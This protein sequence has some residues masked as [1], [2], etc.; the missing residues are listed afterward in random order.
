MI[1]I[2]KI[3]KDFLKSTRKRKRL[4]ENDLDSHVLL[5]D[6][7]RMDLGYKLSRV[8]GSSKVFAEY[9]CHESKSQRWDLCY[10]DEGRNCIEIKFMR[11]IPSGRNRPRTQ[12]YGSIL[13]D[14]FK[15]KL[16]SKEGSD[17]YFILITDEGFK[18]YL[19]RKDFPIQEKNISERS[20]DLENIPK[21]A[22]GEVYKRLNGDIPERIDF[23]M[24][25]LDKEKIEDLNFYL[26]KIM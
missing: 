25:L 19:V 5:E 21:T 13:S 9:P 3:W 4:I 26:M 10:F 8:A 6:T 17:L 11:P 14:L 20:Y 2:R 1:D 18:G 7:F 16:Y 24:K 23:S 22:R 15:L 12:H